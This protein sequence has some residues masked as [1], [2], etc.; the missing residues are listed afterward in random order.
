MEKTTKTAQ[1]LNVS[2]LMENLM[3]LSILQA[4]GKELVSS[5]GLEKPVWVV[6]EGVIYGPSSGHRCGWRR[7]WPWK[8]QSASWSKPAGK[9]KRA[10]E[11]EVWGWDRET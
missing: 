8:S 5:K 2:C 3:L 10:V 11:V 6:H 1:G 4:E 9:V 7:A